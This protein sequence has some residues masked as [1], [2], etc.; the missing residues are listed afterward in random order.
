MA[1][2]AGFVQLTLVDGRVLRL[3]AFSITSIT[4]NTASATTLIST[5]FDRWSVM[6]TMDQ[7]DSLIAAAMGSSNLVTTP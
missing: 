7:V 2:A 1:L 4:T 6:E 3:Q 5:T